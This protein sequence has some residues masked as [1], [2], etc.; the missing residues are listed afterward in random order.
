MNRPRG[1]CQ[2][3]V[4]PW[5]HLTGGWSDRRDGGRYPHV[6]PRCR[7]STKSIVPPEVILEPG[8]RERRGWRYVDCLHV[9]SWVIVQMIRVCPGHSFDD[10]GQVD[11]GSDFI[12]NICLE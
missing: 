1:V 10:G 5:E 12:L 2:R 6:D 4:L 3:D 7:K 8:K 9:P 11:R